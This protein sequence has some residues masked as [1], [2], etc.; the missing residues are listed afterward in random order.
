[1]V[2]ASFATRPDQIELTGS[3]LRKIRGRLDKIVPRVDSDYGDRKSMN[4]QIVELEVIESITPYAYPVVEIS[5][6][7]PKKKVTEKTA[8]G[9]TLKS[10]EDIGVEDFQDCVGKFITMENEAEHEYG[11]NEDTGE[12]IKGAVWRVIAVEGAGVASASDAE[13][14]AKILEM[15]DGNDRAEFSRL[16]LQDD[17]GRQ[18]N[19][20]IMDGSL[21][22]GLIAAGKVEEG[23]DGKYVVAKAEAS[24]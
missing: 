9:L 16:A 15:L 19:S 18:L 8:W 12:T 14:E 20:E 24:A 5:I 4:L 10:L 6:N 13:K 21:V 17:V 3:P 23:E 22:A 7:Y 11:V 2:E 1:M